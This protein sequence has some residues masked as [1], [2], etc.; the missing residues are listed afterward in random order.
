[1][2]APLLCPPR[3][4]RECPFRRDVPPGIWRPSEYRKLPLYDDQKP[5]L[6]VFH[7]HQENATGVPTVCRGWL[8]VFGYDAIAV[9]VAVS[10]G[11]IPPEEVGRP[12][13]VPLYASGA[14]ACAAG[15]AG[16]PSPTAPARRAIERLV[17]K[18]IGS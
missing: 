9:R 3:P 5:E 4:C 13:A 18:G 11:Q 12:C 6:A 8:A 10:R 15:L 14:E 7:C 2:S 1:M 17:A 16:V